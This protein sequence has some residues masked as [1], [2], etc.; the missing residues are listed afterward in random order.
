M[1]PLSLTEQLVDSI[2][3]DIL[4]GIYPPDTQLRQDALADKHGVSRIPVRE[5]LLQLEAEGLVS[6]VP[7]KGAVVTGLSLQEVNDVFELRILLEPRLYRVSAPQL[8]S[9]AIDVAAE[10]NRRY[11]HA[12]EHNERAQ[13]GP[14]NAELHMALYAEAALP[15]TQQIVAALLQTS[16]RY[17]R[18]QLSTESALQQSLV[19]HEALID[20]TRAGR[21]EQAEVLLTGHLN[22]VWQGLHQVLTKK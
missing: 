3:Q 14:L 11:R 5:A 10:V 2:R 18:L 15:K 19:E 22:H 17:T 21:F 7:R 8:N 20:L 1:K 4:D 6:I 13:L 9:A 16:E 12:I